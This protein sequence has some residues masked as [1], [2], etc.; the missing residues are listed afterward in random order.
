MEW[1]AKIYAEK[2][3]SF[4]SVCVCV[5]ARAPVQV[6]ISPRAIPSR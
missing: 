6:Q 4:Y 2:E 1:I 3:A 5:R